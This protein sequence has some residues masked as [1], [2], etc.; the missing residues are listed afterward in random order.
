MESH[1]ANYPQGRPPTPPSDRKG[2]ITNPAEHQNIIHSGAPYLQHQPRQDQSSLQDISY[3]DKE[4]SNLQHS[5][6]LPPVATA[7]SAPVAPARAPAPAPADVDTLNDGPSNPF[8]RKS[9]GATT[10][11]EPHLS[12]TPLAS[13]ATSTSGNATRNLHSLSRG[14]NETTYRIERE[15]LDILKWRNP[16]RSAMVFASLVGS[17]LLTRWYSLLQI[18]SASVTIAIAINLFYV[19]FIMQSQKVLNNQQTAT[20]PY[21]D[22]INN[23]Q[24]TMMIDRQSV[25]HYTSIVT[26]VAETVIR[27]L[28]R[29]IFI[30]D[31][32]TSLKWMAIFFTVW[33]VSAHMKTMNIVLAVIIS[34]FIFPRL[35][36]SNKDV[37]DAHLQKG[38]TLVQNGIQHAQNVATNAAQDT[39]AKSRAFVA[40]IGTSKTDAKNT[41]L[42]SSVTVKED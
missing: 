15:V 25:R 9:H 32:K 8:L 18:G 13:T 28:T 26:D 4:H 31:T 33:K 14:R 12:D 5:S 17:I 35:Y 21:S 41:L 37:V 6:G 40:K 27:A 7:P 34:A 1:V 19:H 3:L 30:E 36:I 23:N 20:H 2:S 10:G 39:Y 16:V 29:I 38:Q 24:H 11:N 22:V 42:N